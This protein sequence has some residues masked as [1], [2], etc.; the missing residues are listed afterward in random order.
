MGVR[1]IPIIILAGITIYFYTILF[2]I[3]TYF[4]LNLN[5]LILIFILLL[6]LLPAINIF[7][8][9]FLTLLHLFEIGVVI[10]ILNFLLKKMNLK[11]WDFLYNS[12]LLPI[13][14]TFLIFCYG[15][16]NINNIKRVE[17]NLT[18]AKNINRE[19]YKIGFISD[20]H[21]GNA[22]NFKK[23]SNLIIKLNKEKFDILLLGGDIV[24]EGTTLKEVQ[25][26]FNLLGNVKTQKG[27]Y[28]IYGNHDMSRY[29]KIPNYTVKDLKNS[30]SK[31][32]IT[33]LED[34]WKEIDD[35]LIIIG[36]KDK[37]LGKRKESNELIKGLDLN[38]YLILLDHQPMELNTNSKLGYN[39]QL[40]GHTH[41][42]Q[43]FP[44]NLIIKGFNL[45]ELIYGHKKIENFDVIVSSGVSGWGYPIKTVGKSE[46]IVI[47]IFKK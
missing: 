38:K 40:S 15:Y 5:K 11:Y 47:N 22:I 27:I 13:L 34:S 45:A 39:L 17:Y 23:L 20:L 33:L 16:Y 14:L 6:I 28:F 10:E 44:F 25:E 36:R 30:I 19:K 31:N 9:W 41:N 18:T 26:V 1:T 3:N 43:I 46:Y 12:F 42:G 35:N 21:F 7:G 32:Q 24:D 4:K 37:S 8:V 2:R 29:K